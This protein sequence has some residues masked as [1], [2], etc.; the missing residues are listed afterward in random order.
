[1]KVS[2]SVNNDLDRFYPYITIRST[3]ASPAIK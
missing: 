3:Q 2:S 1:V